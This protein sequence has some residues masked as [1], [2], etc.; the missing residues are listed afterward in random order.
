M[1]LGCRGLPADGDPRHPD[2]WRHRLHLGQ[3]HPSL[4]QAGQVERDPVRRCQRASRE[5]DAALGAPGRRRAMSEPTEA[6]VRAE[7][8]SW[9]EANWNPELGLVEWRNKLVESGWGAPH[10]PKQ[11]Y[12]RDLP[13]AFNSVVDEEFARISPVG[14]AKAHIRTRAAATILAHGTDLHKGKYL[15]RIRTGEDTWAQRFNEPG[16]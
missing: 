3:R 15:K 6:S 8:R 14:V 10:W 1:G 13:G 11:W 12:C 4:V 5:D 2:A 16:S 9:L 7:V